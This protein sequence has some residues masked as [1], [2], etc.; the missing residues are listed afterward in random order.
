[1]YGT[2]L[3]SIPRHATMHNSGA[4]NQISNLQN[5]LIM[6]TKIMFPEVKR[7]NAVVLNKAIEI[8]ND[9]NDYKRYKL[10]ANTIDGEPINDLFI[11]EKLLNKIDSLF[12]K[13]VD[14]VYKECIAGVTQYFKDEFEDDDE[15]IDYE[16][17]VYTHHY[18]HKQIVDIQRTNDINLLLACAKAG[19]KDLY[20]DLRD[21]QK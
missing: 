14:V 18:D 13:F 3:G 9:A 8:G 1:M 15:E 5:Y 4:D 2:S 12:G 10:D 16:D 6:E 21:L 20:A 7:V 11:G 19:M 17:A